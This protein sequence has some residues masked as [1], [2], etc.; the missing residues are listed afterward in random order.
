MLFKTIKANLRS[1]KGIKSAENAKS[2]LENKGYKHVQTVH[3]G[4]NVWSILMG[5]DKVES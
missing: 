3:T 2:R 5:K 4:R 1:D